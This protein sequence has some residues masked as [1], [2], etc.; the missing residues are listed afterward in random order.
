[1]AD[2]RD[3][4]EV[5]GVPKNAT[6]DEIKKAYRK[7]AKQYHPDLNPGD[8]EAEAKFKEVNEAYEVLSDKDKK[9]RY[10]Q[11]GHAGVDPNFGGGAGGGSPFSGDI[12]LGDIF[13][14]FFGGFG[15][16]RQANPNAPR[17]GSDT[18]AVVN[19]SF[20]EAA[21]GCRKTVSFNKVDACA[22]CSGTG[23]KKGTSAKTCSQCGGSGQ[24]RINQRTPFG[25]VQ[26]ARTCD[27]CG[28]TGKVIETPCDTC[29]GSGKVRRQKSIEINIPAGI[30]NDQMLNVSGQGNAGT[31][32]GPNGDLHVYV[33]VRPHPIFERRGDDIWCEMPITFTQA[34]LGAEVVVPTIDGK[35]SYQVREGTQPGDVFKLKG[36]GIPHINGRGRGDQFV[37]MTIEVPKNLSQKQKDILKE[38]DDSAEEKNYQKRKGFFDKL[39][40]MFDDKK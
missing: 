11:F 7:L 30:D 27:R 35:V 4:Y 13:N 14:S 2:K 1:M 34:A 36:K 19:I 20:E 12:D 25:M 6:D 21:K 39:K 10:D 22:D 3:F 28:G 16:Q 31:N 29:K 23:A 8:K 18:E 37:R 32:G 15:G 5:M 17:R 33:N 24:V 26:T 9:A 38:F 40:E